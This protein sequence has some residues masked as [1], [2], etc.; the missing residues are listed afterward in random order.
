MKKIIVLVGIHGSG[1]ST[2]GRKLEKE[3]FPFFSEIGAELRK[4]SSC[5]VSQKQEDFDALVMK[6][7]LERDKQ[8]ECLDSIPVIESWHIGNIAFAEARNS[9]NILYQ[10]KRK[11]FDQLEIFYPYIINLEISKETF[12]KRVNEKL[13]SPND[14]WLFYLKQ[15]KYTDKIVEMIVSQCY[16]SLL[17]INNYNWLKDINKKI[18]NMR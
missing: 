12:L 17:D 16:A 15:K 2:L 5:N 13:I 1:K 8:I 7:E 14:A 18:K 9:S 10:Y 11:L 3:G 6:R 4:Y